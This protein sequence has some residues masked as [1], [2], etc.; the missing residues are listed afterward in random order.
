MTQSKVNVHHA[1]TPS[2]VGLHR[3]RCV[4][5]SHGASTILS[6][7]PHFSHDSFASR[8]IIAPRLS[9]PPERMDMPPLKAGNCT[10]RFRCRQPD[11]LH[12]R[13][14]RTHMYKRLS[15][16]PAAIYVSELAN[17]DAGATIRRTMMPI[18]CLTVNCPATRTG[19]LARALCWCRL[20]IRQRMMS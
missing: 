16:I 12:L 20:L 9:D 17:N 5:G 11:V 19:C 15:A 14:C 2:R 4:K 13:M 10:L 7:T 18:C 3:Y 8:W 6:R 1:V